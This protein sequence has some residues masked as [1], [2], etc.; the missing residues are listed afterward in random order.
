MEAARL[1]DAQ[2]DAKAEAYHNFLQNVFIK[3]VPLFN[4]E[5]KLDPT[6]AFRATQELIRKYGDSLK[7]W[8]GHPHIIQFAVEPEA[9]ERHQQ[10]EAIKI[11]GSIATPTAIG[12]SDGN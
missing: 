2:L 9:H 10:E 1:P 7:I 4:S 3:S 6:E 11:L 5:G 12:A 8:A